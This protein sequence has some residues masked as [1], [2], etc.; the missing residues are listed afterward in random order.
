MTKG[1]ASNA[2]NMGVNNKM[3]TNLLVTKNKPEN[4]T[5][6]FW[7]YGMLIHA[8]LYVARTTVVSTAKLLLKW[9]SDSRK[10]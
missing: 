2:P 9:K 7:A 8:V 1:Y 6:P 10:P 3:C 4:K 5:N